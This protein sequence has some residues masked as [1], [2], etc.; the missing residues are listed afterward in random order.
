MNKLE[1]LEMKLAEVSAEIEAFKQAATVTHG[2]VKPEVGGTY[3][4][5]TIAGAINPFVWKD[6][7][8]CNYC[9]LLGNAYHAETEAQAAINKKQ[10]TVRIQDRLHELE[11]EPVDWS[12]RG[13][14][15]YFLRYDHSNTAFCI[16]TNVDYQTQGAIYSSSVDAWETVLKEM[17][18][19]CKLIMGVEL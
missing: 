8:F 1:E 14:G 13:A 6:S 16:T 15:K 7:E 18:A 17:E 11:D 3:Y 4:A 19:D 10:A 12:A 5:I 2:R 9:W